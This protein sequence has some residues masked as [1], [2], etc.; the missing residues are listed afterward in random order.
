M[1]ETK[2]TGEKQRIVFITNDKWLREKGVLDPVDEQILEEAA[3]SGGVVIMSLEE[4][5][6]AMEEEDPEKFSEFRREFQK[7]QEISGGIVLTKKDIVSL[8]MQGDRRKRLFDTLLEE[9]M[10]REQAEQIALW[11]TFSR[12][13]WRSVARAAFGKVAGGYWKLWRWE[14]PSNEILGMALCE[15]AAKFFN[16]DYWKPP[17]N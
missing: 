13:T 1:T 3:Q 14:P 8:S 12:Y 5:M 2:N 17:W 6:I 9:K 16:Q 7:Q 4:A 11:R 10:T 15:R